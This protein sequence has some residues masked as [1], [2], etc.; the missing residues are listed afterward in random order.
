MREQH[1]S[2]YK[3]GAC[4]RPTLRAESVQASRGKPSDD[5]R[6]PINAPLPAA[7]R[8]SLTHRVRPPERR[9]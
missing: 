5:D 1:S 4:Q 9:R 7:S 6:R 2:W 3:G 8:H